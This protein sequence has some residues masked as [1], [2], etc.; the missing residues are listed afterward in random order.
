MH[1]PALI[2]NHKLA[3][4]LSIIV[5][6][7]AL[8]C[9]IWISSTLGYTYSTGDRAGFL[10]KLSKRGWL[11]K[12]WEGEMQLTAIPGAAPEKFIFSV[13]SDSIAEELNKRLG[14][15]VDVTYAQHKGVPTSCFG[16]TEY[17]V[18]A[19]RSVGP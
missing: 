8:V 2:R 10:Q 11:C 14:Q 19:V 9:T 12:T 4:T 15:H 7:P 3:T 13:R 5:V 18:T 1:I 6:V 17:F 16:D